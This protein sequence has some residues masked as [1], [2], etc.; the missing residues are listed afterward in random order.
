[1]PG[2]GEQSIETTEI[3]EEIKEE[4][5]PT[6]KKH[7]GVLG[8]RLNSIISAGQKE[9]QEIIDNKKPEVIET[10][11]DDDITNLDIDDEEKP[12][13]RKV[14]RLEDRSVPELVSEV[15]K[16][17]SISEKYKNENAEPDKKYSRFID[18]LKKDFY[19]AY[20]NHA[21]EFGL[22]DLSYLRNQINSVGDRETRIEQW[23]NVELIPAIEKKFKLEPG[24]FVS[25]PQ[26]LYRKGTPTEM[27][28]RETEYKEKELD[29]EFLQ[30]EQS[31]QQTVQRI[32][33][34]QQKDFDFLKQNYYIGEE[35]KFEKVMEDFNSIADR[36]AKGEVTEDKNPFAVR[37]IFR[38]VYFNE[39][40]EALVK[41]AEENLHKQ[42]NDKG[43]FLPDADRET[44]TDVTSIKGTPPESRKGPT[45]KYSQQF[46]VFS[47]YTQ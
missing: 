15:K 4:Q 34:Q 40:A 9:Q 38:G 3:V 1:M 8:Q 42:Y 26:D 27:F 5:Q 37:N 22:P 12:E 46:K 11:P 2:E 44:P 35:E 20:E 41:K 32:A 47:K 28:R 30:Q 10:K 25:D 23:Q 14:V 33:E 36:L 16:W 21:D 43:L 6:E 39:L 31:K 29:Q 45:N 17:M 13:K 18:D 24:T 19:R 7:L